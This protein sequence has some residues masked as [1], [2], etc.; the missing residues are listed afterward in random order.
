M[1][2]NFLSITNWLLEEKNLTNFSDPELDYSELF[3]L[4]NF[5][6][7]VLPE[8]IDKDLFD[9]NKYYAA[10]IPKEMNELLQKKFNTNNGL[11][12]K[13]K[14]DKKWHPFIDFLYEKFKNGKKKIISKEAL[15]NVYFG[16][17][18]K[19]NDQSFHNFIKNPK[20]LETIK[21]P[22]LKKYYKSFDWFDK[23]SNDIP[24]PVILNLNNKYYLVGGN[25][26]LCWLLSKGLKKIPVWII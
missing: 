16:E 3:R 12:I 2:N 22:E 13:K 1:K 25:R 20:Y 26:R 23:H 11:S 10:I 15:S 9:K 21:D 6:N 8:D 19:T 7:D 4:F 14:L 5:F 18:Y 17:D 24:I